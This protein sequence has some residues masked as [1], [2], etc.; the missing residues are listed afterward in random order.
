MFRMVGKQV[1]AL[2]QNF[3][4]REAKSCIAKWRA[5]ALDFAEKYLSLL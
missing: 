3:P 2:Q 4:L 5:Q 1:V